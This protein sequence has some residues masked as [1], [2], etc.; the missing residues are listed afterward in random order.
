M[1]GAHQRAASANARPERSGGK[2]SERESQTGRSPTRTPAL[3]PIQIR[4]CLVMLGGGAT[5]LQ[6]R[7]EFSG[8]RCSARVSAPQ[9]RTAARSEAEESQ[10]SGRERRRLRLNKRLGSWSCAGVEH[11]REV[12]GNSQI[13]S[14]REFA[15]SSDAS[16][17]KS[18]FVL[19]ANTPSIRSRR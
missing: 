19:R 10:V 6:R 11:G 18:Q 9:G 13:I 3:E 17:R 15:R 7:K 8:W 5:Y 16:A 4:R 2:P 1:P 12:V 14:L